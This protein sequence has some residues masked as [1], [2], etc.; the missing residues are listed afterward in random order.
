MV[1][2]LL[3]V[4]GENKGEEAPGPCLEGARVAGI[5]L[6]CA[7][8]LVRLSYWGMTTSLPGPGG[9]KAVSQARPGQRYLGA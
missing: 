8:I 1:S 9:P 5:Y 2:L 6:L 7:V 3:I 4:F